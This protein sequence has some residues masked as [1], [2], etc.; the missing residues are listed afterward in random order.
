MDPETKEIDPVIT[1]VL[2][3]SHEDELISHDDINTGQIIVPGGNSLKW[4]NDSDL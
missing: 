3:E 1:P 4:V 2:P